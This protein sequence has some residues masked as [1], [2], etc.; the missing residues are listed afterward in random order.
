MS[1]EFA[2]AKSN[3]QQMMEHVLEFAFLVEQC[4]S[5]RNTMVDDEVKIAVVMCGIPEEL[6][7]A[8]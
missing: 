1:Y 6:K 3:P 2:D 8:V 4:G 7:A 5:A